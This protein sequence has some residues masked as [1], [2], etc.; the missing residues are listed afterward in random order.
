MRRMMAE[1]EMPFLIALMI[2]LVAGSAAADCLYQGRLYPEGA[3]IGPYV[4][5]KGQ[6]LPGEKS[7][8]P[9]PRLSEILPTESR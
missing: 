4:C 1:T 7:G 6:W 3:R 5:V 9:A 2:V 8:A